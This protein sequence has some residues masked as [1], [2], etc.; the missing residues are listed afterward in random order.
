M[1][2]VR[3]I[4][5]SSKKHKFFLILGQ[6]IFVF[7]LFA[8]VVSQSVWVIALGAFGIFLQAVAR[9]L[10]WWDRGLIEKR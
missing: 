2:N 5:A 8:L 1:G 7:A 10:D 6:L 9:F 3:I 4:H